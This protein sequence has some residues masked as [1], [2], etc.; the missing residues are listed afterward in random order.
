[1][2]AAQLPPVVLRRSPP[3]TRLAGAMAPSRWR[4]MCTDT[5]CCVLQDDRIAVAA[6][7]KP[8]LLDASWNAPQWMVHAQLPATA[9]KEG[10]STSSAS[11][12]SGCSSESSGSERASGASESDSSSDDSSSSE[13]SDAGD[14]SGSDS[15]AESSDEEA[16]QQAGQRP[17][18]A[19][20]GVAPGGGSAARGAEGVFDALDEL[21]MSGRGG[22]RLALA[23][24]KAATASQAEAPGSVPRGSGGTGQSSGTA[25]G[26]AGAAAAPAARAEQTAERA[27]LAAATAARSAVANGAPS[28]RRQGAA[29]GAA[30]AAGGAEA[31]DVVVLG[32]KRYQRLPEKAGINLWV[33]HKLTSLAAGSPA[34]GEA[35]GRGTPAGRGNAS[36]GPPPQQEQQ[37][38][39]Q[40]LG[41]LCH[42]KATD[43]LLL[44]TN[45]HSK[46]AATQL[47][48]HPALAL[49]L[50]QPERAAGVLHLAAPGV[51][52]SA[53]LRQLCQQLRP[54]AAAA[55]GQQLL[56]EQPGPH[57]SSQVCTASCGL[58]VSH[59]GATCR[60]QAAGQAK[61]AEA[62]S[63]IS[64]GP[65]PLESGVS[66]SMASCLD[67]HRPISP[68][69]VA[70]GDRTRG[71]SSH[72]CQAQPHQQPHLPAASWRASTLRGT[73]ARCPPG[74][75][76]GR[77]DCTSC[78][79]WEPSS[80][81]Q[82][83]HCC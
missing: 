59:I 46:A 7:W 40:V 65:C 31:S 77:W 20:P 70:A 51:A 16:G 54:L 33:C 13:V 34:V 52:G 60:L 53:A 19:L 47:A 45:V 82:R 29:G 55:G 74:L 49:L 79:K 57:G 5:L 69:C 8:P 38:Q 63:G 15:S 28:R 26:G 36:L 23:H 11:S 78:S 73:Q 83:R 43:Q 2:K 32:G 41:F 14:S 22:R 67:P 1:M 21:L 72:H 76:D 61:P 12:S 30:A 39:Q 66:R 37:Q 3:G 17:A 24:L 58:L 9:A 35:V 62:A 48:Q 56:L 27:A 81:Q 18:A 71:G 50:Q 10:G 6:I 44:L 68:P 80:M 64:G 75:C 4:W 25:A 42:L